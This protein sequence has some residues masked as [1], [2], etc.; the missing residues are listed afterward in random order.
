MVTK[1]TNDGERQTETSPAMVVMATIG[2]TTWRMFVPVFGGALI[3]YGIDKLV[4][5]RPVGVLAGTF[6][7]II[8]AVLLVVMQYK[9]ATK[10]IKSNKTKGT[11]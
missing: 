10:S 9:A 5:S 11:E 7:G 2:D 3:G 4:A 1:P 8:V 6:I